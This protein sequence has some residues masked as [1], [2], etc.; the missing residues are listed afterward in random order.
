MKFDLQDMLIS[1]LRN[2]WVVVLA[3]VITAG[4]TYFL[5]MRQ[6]PVYQATTTVELQPSTVLSDNQMINV[7]NVL[8]N[9]RTAINTYAR[10]ATSSTMK[11]AVATR[12]GVPAAVIS[13]ASLSAAVLPETTLIEIRGV[14][15]DPK[16]AAAITDTVA[17]EL[18]KQAP[19]M[20]LM[21]EI[22]DYGDPASSPISPQP[23]RLL[24]L[25]LGTGV[26]LGLVCVLLI[27]VLQTVLRTRRL[28]A[29]PTAS[30]L[31]GSASQ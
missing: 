29:S 27:Y 25:G 23:F 31:S 15:N 4:S 16:L 20:V 18:V 13:K 12:L 21:I 7:L 9:R 3:I 24:S 5:G 6:E 26:G 1:M 30:S 2:W 11:E 10:K 8:S 17:E 14:A 19:T 22:I 28:V